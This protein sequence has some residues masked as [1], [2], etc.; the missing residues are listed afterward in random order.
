M[1]PM[2][3][4]FQRVFWHGREA[5]A[6]GKGLFTHSSTG[7]KVAGLLGYAEKIAAIFELTVGK[8]QKA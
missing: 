5:M 7:L 4:F 2:M 1:T 6:P 3:T 8:C